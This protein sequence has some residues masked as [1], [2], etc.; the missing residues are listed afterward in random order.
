MLLLIVLLT[1]LCWIIYE[2]LLSTMSSYLLW[3]SVLQFSLTIWFFLF[4]LW[5]GSYISKYVKNLEKSFLNVEISLA[6]SWAFS[7][8]LIKYAYIYLSSYELFFQLFYIL[9]VI[10]IWWLVGLEIPLIASILDKKNKNIQETVWDVFSW[11]YIWSLIWTLLFPFLLLPWLWLTFTA[12]SVWIINLAVALSFIVYINSK[13][14]NTFWISQFIKILVSLLIIIIWGLYTK[15]HLESLWDHF[16][17]KEPILHSSHSQYQKIVVTKRWDDI[18]LY[19]NWHLQFLSLDENRY[20]TSLTYFWKK[21]INSFTGNNLNILILWWW[22]G[23]ATR[24]LIDDIKWFKNDSKWWKLNWKITLVDLDP[25]ITKLAQTNDILL[26]LNKNSLNN[27][28]VEVINDDA[29]KFIKNTKKKYNIIIAD[30]PDPRNIEISKLYSKEFYS[31]ILNILTDKAV[32]TTQSSSAFFSKEAFWCVNKT[33]KW[34]VWSWFQI[35]SHHTYIPSFWDW[36]FN[37]YLKN[38]SFSWNN[39]DWLVQ[40]TFDKDYKVDLDNLEINTLENPNIISYYMI[41]RKRYSN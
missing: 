33:M 20:H 36:G 29:F 39:T 13:A 17:Y 10:F 21:Y 23:L 18:R 24:N 11:D 8:L 26:K 38:I 9:F 30:F 4:W 7:I 28:N 25:E 2:L 40:F 22:D 12:F 3:N 34:L 41:W 15:S 37:T 19:L 27:P 1:S 32:F 31:M 6:L 5:V 16:F 14:K 35:I